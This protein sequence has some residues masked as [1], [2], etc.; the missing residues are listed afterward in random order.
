MPSRSGSTTLGSGIAGFDLHSSEAVRK[1]PTEPFV[2]ALEEIKSISD[3]DFSQQLELGEVR[4]K[5][6]DRSAAIQTKQEPL[7]F[8]YL[9]VI[10]LAMEAGITGPILCLGASCLDAI[11]LD[12]IFGTEKC[13]AG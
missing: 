13:L 5:L 9:E 6:V 7:G 12:Q 4:R 2:S 3:T 1:R 11:T 10:D 8:S